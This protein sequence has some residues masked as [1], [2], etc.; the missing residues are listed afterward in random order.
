MGWKASDEESLSEYKYTLFH[1]AP[2][3][4]AVL[5]IRILRNALFDSY[6]EE[7]IGRGFSAKGSDYFI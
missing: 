5:K 6:K 2:G 3:K 4:P 1:L 7:L